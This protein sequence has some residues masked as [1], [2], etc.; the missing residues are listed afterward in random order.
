M[1]F[2]EASIFALKQLMLRYNLSQ[3]ADIFGRYRRFSLF[4]AADSLV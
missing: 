3:H 2:A 1:L 4:L